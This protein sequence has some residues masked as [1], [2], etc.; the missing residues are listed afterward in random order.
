P[1]QRTG[2]IWF[3]TTRPRPLRKPQPTGSQQPDEQPGTTDPRNVRVAVRGRADSS[4]PCSVRFAGPGSVRSSYPRSIRTAGRGG[5]RSADPCRL[6]ARGE[7]IGAA[8]VRRCANVA[9]SEDIGV[10]TRW[11]SAEGTRSNRFGYAAPGRNRQAAD[12]QPA[13]C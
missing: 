12:Q 7:G 6:V 2:Q 10:V 11:G 9:A 1:A 4:Y 13:P 3:R 5:A 8:A